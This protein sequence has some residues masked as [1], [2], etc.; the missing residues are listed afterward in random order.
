MNNRWIYGVELVVFGLI[1]LRGGWVAWRSQAW[2][3]RTLGALALLSA[4]MSTV[5][6]VLFV[7]NQEIPPL[8]HA[9]PL[10]GTLLVIVHQAARVMQTAP[11]WGSGLLVGIYGA[12]AFVLPRRVPRRRPDEERDENDIGTDEDEAS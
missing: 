10:V 12:M 6:L 9:S 1:A 8:Y 2:W 4:G 7:L 3:A 5:L 11:G